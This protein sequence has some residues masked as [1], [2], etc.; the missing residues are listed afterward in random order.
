KKQKDKNKSKKE[1]AKDRKKQW[2]KHENDIKK[3][4]KMVKIPAM[5][6]QILNDDRNLQKQFYKT[7]NRK[8]HS[9]RDN[10]DW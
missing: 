5:I 8:K 2:E 4:R 6:K 7:K 1:Q 9:P 10:K 3:K